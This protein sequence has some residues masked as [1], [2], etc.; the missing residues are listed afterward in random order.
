MNRCDM[1]TFTVVS[2]THAGTSPPR[3][4][5]RGDMH[6]AFGVDIRPLKANHKVVLITNAR[7]SQSL[8]AE[9]VLP[10]L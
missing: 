8:A 4:G 1:L 5:H 7:K 6:V 9:L 3:F 2:E 10:G